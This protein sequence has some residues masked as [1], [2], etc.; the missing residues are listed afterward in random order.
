MGKVKYTLISPT[1]KDW[2]SLAATITAGKSSVYDK[3]KAIYSWLID[4][5]AYDTSLQI[6]S[7]DE[8]LDKKKGVC[9]AYCELFFRIGQAAGVDVRIISGKDKRSNGTVPSSS[10]HAWVI[11]NK[12]AIDQ[13]NVMPEYII[14]DEAHEEEANIPFAR[15]LKHDTA[16]FVDPTWGA[17]SSEGGVFR[18]SKHDMSWF[19]VSPEM[20]I[21]THFPNNAADQLL[22]SSPITY[23]QFAY[24]PYALPGMEQADFK[25]PQML[26]HCLKNNVRSFAQLFPAFSDYVEF[27]EMPI[28]GSL[29]VNTNYRIK[30]RKKVDCTLALIDNNQMFREGTLDSIWKTDGNHSVVQFT[31]K[32]NGEVRL[33]VQT[34]SNSSERT[35]STILQYKI[36]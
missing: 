10:T 31:P 34:S 15:G 12:G 3:S 32:N 16:I 26:A 7:A 19:D 9:R 21:F 28:D 5:I 35:Y 36:S 6:F 1:K 27:D 14:Y 30:V 20:F 29:K 33:V 25:G 22:S 2:K 4:N 8:A 11:V 17:G 13:K 23:Q 18:K 24:L